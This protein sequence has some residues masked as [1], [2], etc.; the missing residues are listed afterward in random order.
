MTGSTYQHGQP[1]LFGDL[2]ECEAGAALE[3]DI[4]GVYKGA[5]SSKGF[6]TEKIGFASLETATVDKP[7]KK[8]WRS[9]ERA[10]YVF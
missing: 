8:R 1:T 10:M 6:A 2:C 3:V 5:Q 9:R 7:S 4:I